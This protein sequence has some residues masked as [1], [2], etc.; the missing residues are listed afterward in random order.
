MKKNGYDLFNINDSFY[1][2]I[3]TPYKSKDG[4][5]VLLSDRKNDYYDNNATTCQA[6][7]EY[8]AYYS[9]LKYLKCECNVVINEEI[10]T[11]NMEKFSGKEIYK[12][13]YDVL[14][15]SN[16]KVLKCFKL[17]FD[18]KKITQNLGGIFVFIFFFI[19]LC[20]LLA[21]IFKGINKLKADTTRIFLEINSKNDKAKN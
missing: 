18:F 4:T 15:Y 6:N 17:V 7:C 8:S 9:E 2:D 12:S 3:C 19:Y 13:F 20:F 16:Y 21:F 10:E 14:K 5:D 1:Q 11:T